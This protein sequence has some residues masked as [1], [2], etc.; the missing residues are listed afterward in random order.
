MKLEQFKSKLESTKSEVNLKKDSLRR[1]LNEV[2]KMEK[3]LAEI[4]EKIRRE[5]EKVSQFTDEYRSLK[6]KQ[7]EAQSKM[8]SSRSQNRILSSLMEQQRKGKLNGIHG[9]LGD[10]GA[11][12][13][14]YDIA[15]STACSALDNI[16]TDTI[17]SAQ[18][19]VRYLRESG[20]GTQT[21]IA[22]DK[23]RYLENRWNQ[24]FDAPENVPRLF[25]LI[26]CEDKF[27]VAFL[28]LTSKHARG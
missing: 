18:N 1:Y 4:N 14:K 8:N 11:I 27:K 5:E 19:A 26:Q 12:D 21:F 6:S 13:S 17:E 9:R 24:R 10:L 20:I 16:I 23:Q 28:L 25:D 3:E 2:P 7:S 22:L 15:V